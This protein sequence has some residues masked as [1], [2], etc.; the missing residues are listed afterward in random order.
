MVDAQELSS[1]LALLHA[2]IA[3]FH[4]PPKGLVSVALITRPREANGPRI[5][6]V[7][8]PLELGL[9]SPM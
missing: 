3:A 4:S 9:S 7:H 1:Y 8:Y 2:E 5:T 6:G